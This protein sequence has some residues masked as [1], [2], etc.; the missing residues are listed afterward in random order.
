[1]IGFAHGSRIAILGGSLT[2]K[3]ALFEF[4]RTPIFVY[5]FSDAY[6]HLFI[7][8]L[9]QYKGA[10]SRTSNHYICSSPPSL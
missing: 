1:M 5:V 10:L 6:Y 8:P 3:Y 9:L 7:P 4:Y 2:N